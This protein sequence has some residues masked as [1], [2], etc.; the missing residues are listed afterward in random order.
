MY[1]IIYIGGGLNYA[2]AVVAAKKGLKVALIEKSL[3]QLGGICLHKGCIPSKMFL[4]HAKTLWQSKEDIFEGKMTL[5]MK[6]MFDKKTKL[7]ND[8]TIA[9]TAQCKQIELIEGEGKII[10]AHKV[11]VGKTLYEAK[12]IVIGTGSTPFIPEGIAYDAKHI[13]TSDEVLDLTT[14][15]KKIAI[16]GDGAIGLEMASFFAA[17]GV[18]VTLISRKETLLSHA[19]PLIQGGMTKQIEQMGI[20]H[21]TNHP[22]MIAKQTSR[23]VHVTFENH[24]SLYTEMLLVATGRKPNTEVV[25][26]KDIVVKRGIQT[27]ENF[28]T[29]LAHHYAIGDCNGKVQLAHAA[30]AEVLN[31]T[32]Q[33]L[34]EKPKKLN[35]DL[36]VK[37]IH[38]LPMSY[39]S[40]GESRT[41]LEKK[42]LTHK[43]SIMP[44]SHFTVSSFR[45]AKE[46]SVIVYSDAEGFIV[47]GE[48]LAPDAEELIAPIA[49]ALVGEMDAALAQKTIMAH[50]TFSEAVERAYFRL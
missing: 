15:P 4:H 18:E 49:M 32:M 26:T 43:E 13:I 22:I 38:T 28:E 50:P 39:A 48:I 7:I 8:T 3:S 21:L 16:Y 45:D 20:T 14:L 46:G 27:D 25:T 44:L 35:L 37:F 29:T 34:G 12:D 40:V 24:K 23:G 30:K 33:I 17:S 5:N 41:M 6:R 42:A 11:Q 36:V 31:V 2:G 19:H 1:D 10:A 9:L 47:G